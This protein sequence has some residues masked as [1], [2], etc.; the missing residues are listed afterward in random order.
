[1]PAIGFSTSKDERKNSRQQFQLSSLFIATAVIASILTAFVACNDTYEVHGAVGPGLCRIFV[2]FFVLTSIP[3]LFSRRLR[4]VVCLLIILGCIGF[5]IRQS[6]LKK[7]LR[8]LK[9]E[10][11]QI[12]VFL[13]AH[14]T[15]NG[16]YPEDL[17]G[18]TFRNASLKPFI[19]YNN[20]RY[21]PYAIVFH[22]FKY[23]GTG[24]WYYPGHG[25]YFEDD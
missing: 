5:S 8:N 4:R 9:A 19:I 1:M 7:R 17:S 10:V 23:T 18:Y 14:Q 25:Y 3:F 24:H 13:E 20:P 21:S 6:V 22:P 2:G 16:R 11:S 12:V 15:N